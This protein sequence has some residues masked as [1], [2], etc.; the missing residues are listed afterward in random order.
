MREIG[1]QGVMRGRKSITTVS[2]PEQER[3]PDLVKRQFRATRPY[4]LW[5]ADFTC[6]V[7]WSGFVYVALVVDLYARVIVGWRVSRS[8]ETGLVLDALERVIRARKD[9]E[10]LIHHSDRGSVDPMQEGFEMIDG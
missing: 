2:K 8:M 7:T 1:I 5:V 3:A 10:A 9:C 4:Q 6:V